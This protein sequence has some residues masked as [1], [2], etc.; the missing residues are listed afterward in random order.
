MRILFIC[1]FLCFGCGSTKNLTP[2]YS[3]EERKKDVEKLKFIVFW[4]V[5]LFVI[6]KYSLPDDSNR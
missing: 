6:I 4:G 2:K 3:Y 5:I 1:L